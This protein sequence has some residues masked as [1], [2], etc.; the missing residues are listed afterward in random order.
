MEGAG[1]QSNRSSAKG[2]P[3]CPLAPILSWVWGWGRGHCTNSG[4][5]SPQKAASLEMNENLDFLFPEHV[6]GSGII[7]G[8]LNPCMTH[9]MR[10]CEPCYWTEA[11][12]TCGAGSFYWKGHWGTLVQAWTWEA[13]EMEPCSFPRSPQVQGPPRLR[14]QFHLALAHLQIRDRMSQN[15]RVCECTCGYLYERAC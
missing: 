10:G 12:F 4:S 3:M 8:G 15:V 9:C 1:E 6:T 5:E 7:L 2:H 14:P 13:S 11:L